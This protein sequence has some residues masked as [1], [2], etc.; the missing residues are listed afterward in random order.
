M[1]WLLAVVCG[2]LVAVLNIYAGALLIVLPTLMIAGFALPN[3][4]TV[5][6]APAVARSAPARIVWAPMAQRSISTAD[7]AE[8]QALVVPSQQA[9]GYQMVLTT[10][11]YAL[12]D[13]QGQVVYTLKR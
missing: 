6:P 9:D 11:G 13:D 1:A 2:L 4:R 8:R 12:V 5:Q 7:G 3:G 10:D